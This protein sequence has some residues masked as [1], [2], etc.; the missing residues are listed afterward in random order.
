[1][2]QS[3]VQ[4]GQSLDPQNPNPQPPQGLIWHKAEGY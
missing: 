2:K 4:E 1:M 3:G